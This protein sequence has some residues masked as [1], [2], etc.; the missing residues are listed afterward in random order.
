MARA[1]LPQLIDGALY[2]RTGDEQ[3]RIVLE[4]PAW[5]A[6]LDAE[7]NAAFSV[8]SAGGAVTVRREQKGGGAYWYAYHRSGPR[9]RKQYLGKSSE[10]SAG[11]IGEAV[12]A[13]TRPAD[14]PD[15]DAPLRLYLLGTPR[16]LRG[17]QAQPL[18]SAKGVALLGYLALA[19]APQTREQL[20]ALLWPE[21]AEEAARK[22]LRN[23]LW[24]IRASLG[25][26]VLIAEGERL[27]LHR[28]VWTD[29]GA[30]T[31][32]AAAQGEG[33]AEQ[34]HEALACY[35][36][37]LLDGLTLADAPEFELWLGAERERL[38]QV[39][40]GLAD[41]L[42]ARQRAAGD[43]EGL[44]ATAR[45]ALSQDGGLHEGMG[46]ALIEAL[47]RRGDRAGALR[48][49]E[50]LRTTLERELGA[51]PAPETEALREALLHGDLAGGPAGQPSL[52][53]S[54]RAPTPPAPRAQP[55]SRPF[56][57]R[58]AEREA[59][60]AELAGL[61]SLRIV[62]LSG[63][64][65][66]GKSQLWQ[67]WSASVG[68]AG[69]IEIA[70][71]EAT[72]VLPFAPLVALFSHVSWTA[73]VAAAV[74][75]TLPP[76]LHEL[77]RLLPSL[78]ELLPR[79]LLGG[80]P[81]AEERQGLFE[82]F[83]QA[84][85][86]VADAPRVLFVDDIHWADQATLDWLDYAIHRLRETPLLLV[87]AYRSEDAPR[88]LLRRVAQWERDGHVRR[89]ALGRLTPDEAATL[90]RAL[91][92]PAAAH[93]R[94]TQASA[95][96]PYFLSELARAPEA[97]LPPAL[98]DL[99]RARVEGLPQA[100]R[101]LLQAAAVLLPDLE[102]LALQQ[103]SGH[104]EAATLDALDTLLES[105][106]LV[107]Q[108]ERFAFS[109]PLVA[110]VVRDA[111][112]RARRASLHR[113]V[114]QAIEQLYAEH[115]PAQAGRIASHYREAGERHRSARFAELAG[116]YAMS[117]AAPAEA[118]A[119]YRHALAD[120]PTP[121]RSLGLG[122]SLAWQGEPEEALALLQDAHDGYLAL[123]DPRGAAH[124]QLVC[125]DLAV[126]RG[127]YAEAGERA[128]QALALAGEQDAFTAAAAHVLLGTA[129]RTRG[130]LV[131]AKA[132]IDT[133]TELAAQH[134]LTEIRLY[135]A[136]ALSNIRAEQGDIAGAHD[137]AREV[138]TYARRTRNPFYEVVGHN[139]AAH[140][141]TQLGD[142]AT[143]HAHIAEG[144]QLAE[145]RRLDMVLQ[146]LYSTR[147]ELAL[148]EQEWQ[149]AEEWLARGLA[150][151]ERRDNQGQAAMYQANLGRA[152]QGR[153]ELARAVAL[154]EQ[155]QQQSARAGAHYQQIQILLWLALA[156]LELGDLARAR[157]TWQRASD[158]LATHGYSQLAR[159]AERVGGLLGK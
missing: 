140:R 44:A 33:G 110:M 57:G 38:V 10:L 124:A 59:L 132:H 42:L 142:F 94:L 135:A 102:R 43:W 109:H 139:N 111:M 45:Q 53:Q 125:A 159:E 114:A 141:A 41:A 52:V 88:G 27:A 68:G 2:L 71:L 78:G 99:V 84:L 8:A 147:G 107:E 130:D 35:G 7:G 69:L 48:Q 30:F 95:G 36:G 129:A 131:L 60:D 157:D 103:V 121:A 119:F 9:L 25:G 32:L 5:F 146:W 90:L 4:S 115:L 51:P 134:E 154:Y 58:E 29:V 31:H 28:A 80:L 18:A 127:R 70:C 85:L 62:V 145:A 20:L 104:D 137:A 89:L 82:A 23:T 77:T 153:G 93:A 138:V 1:A 73:R 64:L 14:T 126:S 16:F 67:R 34:L 158:E 156:Q 47:A 106:V 112:S 56:V 113:R 40:L 105:G 12:A 63:E 76:W 143:A 86:A 72:Q 55:P 6:W 128:E 13:L 152:A 122:R 81:P 46:R 100:A 11:R 3:G 151:A 75:A 50:R 120:E 101:E 37:A 61:E 19:D 144:L 148:A 96:N 97:E 24:G 108:G 83:V 92:A 136:V 155:A 123:D 79:P 15:G 26:E 65:G 21:S 91:E 54:P 22:N 17:T 39:Y 74:G 150:E 98:I 117:V 116:D 66:I 49:Y 118:T 87:V 133:A 149:L